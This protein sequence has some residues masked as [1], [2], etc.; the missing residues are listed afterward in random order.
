MTKPN[1]FCVNAIGYRC[2][3]GSKTTWDALNDIQKDRKGKTVF[4]EVI[5]DRCDGSRYALLRDDEIST[6]YIIEI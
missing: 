2:I 1:D 4:R 5:T 3:W 6:N